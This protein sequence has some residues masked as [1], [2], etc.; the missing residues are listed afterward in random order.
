MY[1]IIIHSSNFDEY[2]LL[3]E[4]FIKGKDKVCESLYVIVSLN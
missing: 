2:C 1:V 3:S 4:R